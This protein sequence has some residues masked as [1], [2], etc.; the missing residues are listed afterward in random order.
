MNAVIALL[1]LSALIGFALGA[2]FS[3]F[4]IMI[5]G[6]VL[7]AIS[8]AALQMQGFGGFWGIAVIAACLTVNQMAYLAGVFG[9]RW[10]YCRKKPT[11]NQ[12]NAATPPLPANDTSNKKSSSWFV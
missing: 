5:S 8:A 2:S 1:A 4:A 10:G 12:A 7:A 6:V 11:R 9:R 3:W